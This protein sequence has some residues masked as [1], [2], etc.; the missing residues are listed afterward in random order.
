MQQPPTLPI[1]RPGVR[2]RIFLASVIT[3]RKRNCEFSRQTKFKIQLFSFMLSGAIQ[4][5]T[6]M[7]IPNS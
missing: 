1:S 6:D 3:L 4:K 5:I 7:D 2:R